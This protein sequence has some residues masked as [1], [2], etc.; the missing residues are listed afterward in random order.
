MNDRVDPSASPLPPSV[1]A[2]PDGEAELRLVVRL[3]WEDVAALGQ[4]AGRLAARMQRAVTLDEAAA[5]RLRTR[6]VSR[7]QAVTERTPPA[8]ASPV[9]P[10]TARSP[11]EHARQAIDKIN[12][13]AVGGH[14]GAQTSA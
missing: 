11:G 7:P 3:G 14:G 4:E 6:P 8:T 12:G 13:S 5:H 10:L 9:S 1:H 2:L